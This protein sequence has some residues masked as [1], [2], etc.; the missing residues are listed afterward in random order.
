MDAIGYGHRAFRV[1]G[2][3]HSRRQMV[4]IYSTQSHRTQ[5]QGMP[6]CISNGGLAPG[7]R[8]GLTPEQIC[9]RDFPVGV[10]RV[11]YKCQSGAEVRCRVCSLLRHA[12]PRALA[13]S[14]YEYDCT[15]Q[16]LLRSGRAATR[17]L[18]RRRCRGCS[19]W[20]SAQGTTAMDL[21]SPTMLRRPLGTSSTKNRARWRTSLGLGFY[22]LSKHA[23]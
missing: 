10:E 2:I 9:K 13:V 7:S 21:A 23:S 6:D 18:E 4:F 3:F 15:C 8:G 14:H 16:L 1:L 12:L 20:A 22:H 17:V 19:I 5:A 11:P